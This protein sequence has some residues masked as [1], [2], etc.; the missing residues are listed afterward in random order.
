MEYKKTMN[1]ASKIVQIQFTAFSCV[2]SFLVKIVLTLK[3]TFILPAKPLIKTFGTIKLS[4]CKKILF[5][6]KTVFFIMRQRLKN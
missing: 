6:L 3:C 5:S 2:A 4:V 1:D